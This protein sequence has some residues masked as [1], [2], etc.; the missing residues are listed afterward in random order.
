VL[1]FIRYKNVIISRKWLGMMVKVFLKRGFGWLDM[2]LFCYLSVCFGKLLMSR[3]LR[4]V[5]EGIIH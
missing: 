1:P 4:L 2:E 3:F 5:V